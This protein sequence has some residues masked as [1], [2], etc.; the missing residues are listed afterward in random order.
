MDREAWK[1]TVYEITKMIYF[2]ANLYLRNKMT[3]KEYKIFLLV[4]D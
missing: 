2:K 4:C 1:A 3:V